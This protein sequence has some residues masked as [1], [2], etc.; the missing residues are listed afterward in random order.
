MC[1]ADNE[2]LKRERMKGIELLNTECIRTL[3]EIL[4][5]D[6]VKQAEIK[7]KFEKSNLE[8]RKKLEPSSAAE[9]PL[10]E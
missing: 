3:G 9:I 8:E 4:E 5:T 2:K 7:E 6:T 1:Q 10:K